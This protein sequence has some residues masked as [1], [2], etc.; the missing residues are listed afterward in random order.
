MARVAHTDSV[1]LD[2]M[3]PA[4][5]RAANYS[6]LWFGVAGGLALTRTRRGRR[7]ALR[8]VAALGLASATVNVLGKQLVGRQRPAIDLVPL[9]RRLA[10]A[11]RTLSFPSG[12]SA[13]AAAFATGVVLESPPLGIP[14]AVL[15]AAVAA[16]RVAV[17]AHYP[18]DVVAG[19]GIGVAAGLLTQT[20]WPRPPLD[21]ASAPVGEAPAL[22]TGD[23]LV[24]VTNAASGTGSDDGLAELTDRLPDAEIVRI[25]PGDDIA[26][27]FDKAAARCAVLG[28]AG[29]DGTVSAAAGVATRRGVPLLVVPSGTL[30][31]FA[32]D[33]G[34]ESVADAVAAVRAG[35]AVRVDVGLAGD[36][37][38]VNT[39]SIG[40]YVDLVRFRGRWERRLGK[41]PAM[42]VGLVHV[43][44]HAEPRW[45]DVDG[46]PRL[47]WM[48][49]AGNCRYRPAGFTPTHRARLDDGRLDVRIVDAA[50]RFARTRIVL[51]ALTRT[52]RWSGAYQATLRSGVEVAGRDGPLGLSVDGEITDGQRVV[53]LGKTFGALTIYRPAGSADAA[54]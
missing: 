32:H 52:L 49:F 18:S 26:G 7:A 33:V 47:V 4:L 17:G 35:T 15:A 28:V 39:A 42:A 34:V 45:V 48:L 13:S 20:W 37:V 2:Q 46:Q 24:L 1:V 5:G 54:G 14:V 44:R 10:V 16:S 21:P 50:V 29:G 40:L 22:P 27:E 38:F 25:G 11:P 8:G 43:L 23:G 9:I 53:R 30:N 12:H 6:R 51:G 3:L 19:L 36:Q 31:H 41:W